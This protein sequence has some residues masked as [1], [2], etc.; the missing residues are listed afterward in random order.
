[1]VKREELYH[2]LFE[3]QESFHIEKEFVDRNIKKEVLS[4]IHLNLPIIITGV[5]RSGKST[6]LC[7][8]RNHLKL[9][10][11]D[12]LYINFNDERLTDF[13][14]EDFQKIID[15]IDEQ[16]YDKNCYLFL[17]EIQ[18][19]AGWEKWVDRIKEKHPILITG[20]NS[21]LLSKEISTIL[22]GR[23]INISL[24]PFSFREFLESRK[25]DI[26][27]WELNLKSHSRIR[28]EFSEY[29]ST[30]GIPKVIVDNDK[31]LLQ[32]NY[33]NILYRDII[34]R[35]NQNLEKP[36]KEISVYL[37]SNISN[38]L[39][40]RALSKT[41]QIKNLSTIKSILDTFEK[42]FVF[43][44]VNKFDFSVRK[45]IQNPRKVYCIDNGFVTKVGFKFSEDKGWLLENLVFLEL[46]RNRKD[47]YYFSEK[48]ECDFLIRQG[49]K[50]IEAIQVCHGLNEDNKE[51]DVNGLIEA[52]ERFKLKEGLILTYDQEDEIEI[53]GKRIKI[54]PVWKWLLQV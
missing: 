22:T 15:F 13:A 4:F 42:A 44:F 48:G 54:M 3:Q 25:T 7:I 43:F 52:L 50:I 9:K 38:R 49:I 31:R 41:A 47:V 26:N 8:I 37:L 17:D 35:F 2:V 36:I 19:T 27:N 28:K 30:G 33:E 6:L 11:K 1:M 39:S 16:S 40:I 12:Y 18:E 53:K 51:R 20:S 14:L 46:K 23:S 34:K 21:K 5:R 29:I 45:Q 10:E 24:Y 32:E